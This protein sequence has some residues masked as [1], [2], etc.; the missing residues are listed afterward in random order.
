MNRYSPSRLRHA[1]RPGAVVC[2]AVAILLAK[3]LAS[4]LHEYPQY[5]PPDFD[6]V[7]LSG[8]RYSFVGAYRVAFYVHIV[9]SPIALLLGAA[10][11]GTGKFRRFRRHHKLTGR[12]QVLMVI[13]LVTPSG[14]VMATQAY[15]GP[16][17]AWGFAMQGFATGAS[18]VLAVVMA[19]RGQ[20]I[21]HQRW[22]TR[23]FLLLCSPLILRVVSGAA[24]AT[25]LESDLLYR[26]NAWLSWIIPL[27]IY[28]LSIRLKSTDWLD[29]R[30]RDARTSHQWGAKMVDEKRRGAIR[31]AFTLVEL[32]VLIAIVGVLIGLLLPSVRFSGEAARRMA[33]SNNFKQLGLAMHNYHSAYRQLPQAM[34][35]TADNRHRLSGL[36]ALTP[37][38]EQQA[39]WESISSRSIFE[40]VAYP[41]MGPPPWEDQYQPWVTQI[42][43]LQC[44]SNPD[45]GETFALTNYTFCIGDRARDIHKPI[46][47]NTL[48]RGTFSVGHTTR[49][50]D[51]LDGLSNTIAAGEIRTLRDKHV[52]SQWASRQPLSILD[53]PAN[54]K[55][56]ADPERPSYF[57]DEVSLGASGRGNRWADGA[58][59]FGLFNT[60]TP[61]NSANCAING[62]VTVDGI[63][64]AASHHAGGTHVLMGDGAVIF[65]TDSVDCGTPDEPTLNVEQLTIAKQSSPHGLWGALGSAIGNEEVDS[66]LNH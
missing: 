11:I 52:S 43:T 39:L 7:F 6:A 25:Q 63:Y 12:V 17:A 20:F 41:P 40:K 28:E 46:P 66:Q 62:D 3:V 26:A 38:I 2:V 27:A 60:I 21:S 57:R 35:G 56:L 33:C 54:C 16:V 4:I 9:A 65:M 49:F 50:R 53:A 37:F 47:E 19:L 51:I 45:Q 32:L 24:I 10:L 13:T 5:F 1:I 44:P 30:W 59:G 61:P 58:A 55:E 34:G 18:A 42:P 8:K 64:V 29:R 48:S 22:A 15:A 14:L 31:Q 23:C 36:V